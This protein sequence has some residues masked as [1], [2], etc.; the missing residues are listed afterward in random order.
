[1]KPQQVYQNPSRAHLT[2]GKGKLT[3]CQLAEYLQVS[4]RQ[5]ENM[6]RARCIP[7]ERY[8]RRCIRFDLAKIDRALE[9]FEIQSIDS[10]K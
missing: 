6:M 1:M 2:A 8:G 10:E 3:K 5:I 9:K 4:P 7:F